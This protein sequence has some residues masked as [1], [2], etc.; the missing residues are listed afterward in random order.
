MSYQYIT[1]YNSPNYTA[2]R[3]GNRV[4]EIVIH[5][6]GADGQSFNGVVNWLCRANGTNSAHYVVESGKVACLVD[7]ANTAWHAGNW[8]HNLKSI[9]I[10]CRPE[11]SAGDLETVCEVVADIYKV[12]GVLPIVGHKDVS[13]TACP[14]R[15]Y[16]KL[17]YIK[18]RAIQIMNG[19]ASKPTT[20]TT[21]TNPTKSVDEI[22]REVIAGKWGNGDDRRNRLTN[23]GYDYNA[24]QARVNEIFNGG[25]TP[26]KSIAQIAKEVIA[27]QW[28]NG[29]DRKNRL[30]AAGYDYNAVQAEVNRQMGAKKSNDQIAR[31]VIQGKWGNGQDRRNRLSAA[32]YNPDTI[33]ALVNKMM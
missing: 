1:K 31:E 9:G 20:P 6:W 26:T 21:P 3:Q 11:M 4:S 19:S 33:Q 23:A 8:A 24:I 7:C 13:A 14:G 2:G 12:Y 28:G 17:G 10:E 15:Y 32:G 18:N 30:T 29:A 16:A 25:S 22:A 5:H 27:G